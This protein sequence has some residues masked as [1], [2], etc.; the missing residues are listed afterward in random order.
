MDAEEQQRR[1]LRAQAILR[2]ELFVEAWAALEQRYIEEW[3]SCKDAERRERLHTAVAILDRVRG[4]IE[5]I[6]G[7]GKLAERRIQELMPRK[8]FAGIV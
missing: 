1:G 6:A 8:K 5:E 7:T 4:H 2:D 3:K